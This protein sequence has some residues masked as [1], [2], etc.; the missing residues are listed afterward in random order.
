[1]AEITPL[2]HAAK[3]VP[4]EG[5]IGITHTGYWGCF[6]WLRLY[7]RGGERGGVSIRKAYSKRGFGSLAR[8]ACTLGVAKQLEGVEFQRKSSLLRT[9]FVTDLSVYTCRFVSMT[10]MQRE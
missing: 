8:V 2:L 5:Y 4:I 7:W 9:F 10:E 3:H 6:A 1:M